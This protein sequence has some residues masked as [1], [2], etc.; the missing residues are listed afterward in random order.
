MSDFSA[1]DLVCPK[2]KTFYIILPDRKWPP[3]KNQFHPFLAKSVTSM[4][5][6]ERIGN[7]RALVLMTLDNPR[8]T[9]LETVHNGQIQRAE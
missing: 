8:V 6:V 4:I 3:R 7:T 9:S 2:F 5:F 1:G